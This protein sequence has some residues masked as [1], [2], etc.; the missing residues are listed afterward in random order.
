MDMIDISLHHATVKA[1]RVTGPSTGGGR[2]RELDVRSLKSD[3]FT[4]SSK[5]SFLY[6]DV[7]IFEL[8]HN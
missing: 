1:E 2:I 6:M 3:R 4:E 8:L 5:P 7:Y